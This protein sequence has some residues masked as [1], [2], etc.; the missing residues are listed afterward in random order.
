MSHDFDIKQEYGT[1]LK[2]YEDRALQQSSSPLTETTKNNKALFIAFLN[3]LRDSA[4]KQYINIKNNKLYDSESILLESQLWS[5][6]RY[7]FESEQEDFA[8]SENSELNR[9]IYLKKWL[10]SINSAPLRP[11]NLKK[12]QTNKAADEKSEFEEANESSFFQ[13]CFEILLT[14]DFE[15]AVKECVSVNNFSLAMI[16]SGYKTVEIQQFQKLDNTLWRKTVSKLSDDTN[17]NK[18]E[19]IIY[20]YLSGSVLYGNDDAMGELMANSYTWECHLLFFLKALIDDSLEATS[21]NFSP[22]NITTELRRGLD[23]VFETTGKHNNIQD[24]IAALI[25]QAEN[26]FFASAK[27]NLIKTFETEE[28]TQFKTENYLLRVLTHAIII[29]DIFNSGFKDLDIKNLFVSTYVSCLR[30]NK[31]HNLIPSYVLFLNGPQRL[32]TYANVLNDVTSV[33]DK[34]EQKI[35]SLQLGLP[36]KD[37]LRKMAEDLFQNLTDD[38]IDEDVSLNNITTTNHKEIIN[39][40]DWLMV[41]GLNN[42]AVNLLIASIKFFLLNGSV[43][44]FKLVVEKINFSQLIA[45][46]ELDDKPF[47]SSIL[48]QLLEL[49]NCF[50]ILDEWQTTI[51]NIEKVKNLS[52]F[53]EKQKNLVEKILHC[54]LNFFKDADATEHVHLYKIKVLYVPYL[55]IQLHQALDF[56]SDILCQKSLAE[57]ALD[58]AAMVAHDEG[59][60]YKLFQLSNKVEEYIQLATKTYIKVY[61]K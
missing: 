55:V 9:V 17:L 34:E 38:A 60:T 2:T 35:L 4:Y 51:A 24:M 61:D 20:K 6:L 59:E 21:N 46:C 39:C 40:I 10:E 30:L 32:V 52:T 13:Y 41:A 58:L 47:E 50:S 5:L 49:N 45:I 18:Y 36:Y 53:A 7:L 57:D 19:R 28:I 56:A 27:N 33:E 14:G 16:I 26:E 37:S 12:F 22:V 1:A 11:L 54:I 31:L 15:K 23:L 43:G 8:I 29:L 42:E 44:T 25:L 3:T 48:N